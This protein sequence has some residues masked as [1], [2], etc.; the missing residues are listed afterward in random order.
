MTKTL[1]RFSA[2]AIKPEFFLSIRFLPRIF[3]PRP[4]FALF[5]LMPPPTPPHPCAWLT[6]FSSSHSA[7]DC[8][9]SSHGPWS[10]CSKPC[11]VGT[12]TR[13]RAVL[14]EA[15]GP[16]AIQCRGAK[17]ETRICNRQTCG[18]GIYRAP[19]SEGR[20]AEQDWSTFQSGQFLALKLLSHP[21]SHTQPGCSE[22]IGTPFSSCK[23]SGSSARHCSC[24]KT[25]IHFVQGPCTILYR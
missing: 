20:V 1:T 13:S 10:P 17:F 22:G 4:N 21:I 16:G 9:W 18:A 12:Q 23:S 3:P 6:W 11:G 24:H 8:T 15:Q 2:K 14:Q 25:Y 5:Q 19:L 7:V